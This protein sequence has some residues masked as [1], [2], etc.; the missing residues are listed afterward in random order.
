MF[1]PKNTVGSDEIIMRFFM[2]KRFILINN[3]CAI[4]DTAGRSSISPS[5]FNNFLIQI[6]D[7]FKLKQYFRVFRITILYF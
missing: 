2:K 1:Y 7:S 6:K 3:I 5:K 4:T